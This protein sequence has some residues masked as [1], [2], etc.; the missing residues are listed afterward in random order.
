MSWNDNFL[1]V[2]TELV[3][4]WG[5][6]Y[7]SV[8][9][10]MNILY[11]WCKVRDKIFFSDR[12]A[13][14]HQPHSLYFVVKRRQRIDAGYAPYGDTTTTKTRVCDAVNERWCHE[15]SPSGSCQHYHANLQSFSFPLCRRAVGG[16]RP[17]TAPTRTGSGCPEP[18]RLWMRLKNMSPADSSNHIQL[19][20]SLLSRTLTPSQP[21]TSSLELM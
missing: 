8:S 20:E 17:V 19:T 2:I 9:L 11:S 10:W 16:C 3:W 7:S 15:A 12:R 1:W 5:G 21:N 13:N 6:G 14:W 18:I 4:G